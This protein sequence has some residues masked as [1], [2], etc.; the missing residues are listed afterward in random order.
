[1]SNNIEKKRDEEKINYLADLVVKRYGM[2]TP[3]I[4]ILETLKPAAFVGGELGK[5][6]LT[7]FFFLVEPQSEKRVREYITFLEDR[8]N[9]ELFLQRIEFLMKQ[10][11]EK[12]KMKKKEKTS[13][14]VFDRFVE[15]IKSVF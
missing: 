8:D 13:K 9:L 14:S 7:P 10:E 1:M 15:K 5:I 12:N 4:M 3:T 6:F 2:G 11:D